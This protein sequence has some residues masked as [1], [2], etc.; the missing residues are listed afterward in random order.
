[1][2]RYKLLQAF[3]EVFHMKAEMLATQCSKTVLDYSQYIKSEWVLILTK[4]E[5]FT[6]FH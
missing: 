3:K 1:M 6:N 5:V 4:C 2:D